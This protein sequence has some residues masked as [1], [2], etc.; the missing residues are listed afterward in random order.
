[1]NAS[2]E[3]ET[4]PNGGSGVAEGT[5]TSADRAGRAK[6]ETRRV[7]LDRAGQTV[8]RRMA[9]A[10]ATAPHVYL[11]TQIDMSRAAEVRSAFSAAAA[12][13][14]PVPSLRDM[15][16]KAVALAL[17]DV[18][19]ANGSYRDGGLELHSRI[20]IGIAVFDEDSVVVPTIADAD[21]L[22][23]GEIA[24]ESRR[25]ADQVRTGQI[26]AAGLSG[27]TF[28]IVDL[29]EFGVR[30]FD[31]VIHG[32]QAAALGTGE[33]A[34]HPIVREGEIVPALLME[35]SL[36]CDHRILYGAEAAR[37]LAGIRTRL[38]EPDRIA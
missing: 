17:R 33:V 1:M 3:P 10:K 28:T 8:A 34:A 18:P 14:E 12:D 13:G 36:A 25:L 37:L 7:E 30:D 6:G 27:G 32:G 20:N 38:E 23:L 22:S 19:R 9:E 29:G 15:L 5:P 21:Q 11:R 4:G 31:P 26:T 24:T 2:L 16:V 35:I